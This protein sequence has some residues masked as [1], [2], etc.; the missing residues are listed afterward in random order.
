MHE[1]I[2]PS[3]TPDR[4]FLLLAF[5]ASSDCIAM[6]DRDA[7]VLVINTSGA[8]SM[9]FESPVA[10]VGQNWIA[11]WSE[12]DRDAARATL[13]A[14]RR[15]ERAS[16]NSVR[17]VSGYPTMWHTIVLALTSEGGP[18]DR[19]LAL[20]RNVTEQ[21][22]AEQAFVRSVRLQQALI[23][24]TSEIVWHVDLTTGRTVRRGYVEFTGKQDDPNDMD[25]WLAAVHPADRDRAKATA[26]KA[27][28]AKGLMLL[29]YRLL[30]K[31]EGWRWVEDQA[32]P[33]ID[34][35]G[36]VTDWV[37]IITDIHDRK[38]AEQAMRKSAEHLRLAVEATGL[39]TW[40]VDVRT[41]QRD[42]SP[43]MFDI[44]GYPRDTCP[45]R[46]LYVNRIH[47]EDRARAE[48]ELVG[49]KAL[50]DRKQVSVFRLCLPGGTLRWVEAHERTFFDAQGEP[51][52]RVGTLQDVTGRKQ[53]EH[54]VWEAAHTDALTGI[55]NRALFNRRLDDAVATAT[56]DGTSVG[57]LLV[58]LD[59]FKEINDTL[60]HDA[61]DSL[62][63]TVA[64]R[65]R[66][67]LVAGATVA[68]LGG[69]EFG[70]IFPSVS[71]LAEPQTYA[72]TLLATLEE[73]LTYGGREV[74]CSASMGWS[75]FPDH[76]EEASAL[77][78]NADVA[79]YAAKS[80]GRGRAL[81][82]TPAMRDELARRVNV[83]RQTKDALVR[84]A[85]VPFYQPKISLDTGLVVGFEAL[86]RWS[87]GAV[88]RSPDSIQEAFDD[89]ELSVK[90]GARMLASTMAD[91]VGWTAAG[92][93]FGHVALNVAISEFQGDCYSERIF[94][95]LDGAGLQSNQLEI[96]VTER[97]LLDDGTGAIG[98][99]LR[100]LHDAG[101]LI[102]LDD[103]G[104]GYASLTHLT[105]F[106][107]TWVK[108]D[109]SF[110][111]N[112]DENRSSTA[113]VRAVIALAHNIGI[114]IVAEGVETE[115]QLA[116][117]AEAGCDLGQ[118]FLLAK[119]MSG[120]RVPYFLKHW[121]SRWATLSVHGPAATVAPVTRVRK[122]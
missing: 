8:V 70:V 63:R 108:I 84:N 1:S 74:D 80:A 72:A 110:I 107:V 68:R 87:D 52:R 114:K 25:G 115:A 78:K 89:P 34:E 64:E 118:G 30:H 57:L 91:M 122:R 88:L 37:G 6:L 42:W 92:I 58:D 77:L 105:K 17:A 79:L 13:E 81:A 112:P 76:D 99:A 18:S 98:T 75:V 61:G 67:Q 45:D 33:L 100:K 109:R 29:E 116:F 54:E 83:L 97:V 11:L 12:A 46:S 85:I 20:S 7:T 82:F 39:G 59:R 14:A 62:L 38:S 104:T 5:E 71:G 32:T 26:D 103:F 51:V 65:L 56:A 95:A 55:A 102:A 113:I 2:R 50:G 43:E 23:E 121:N 117:L 15:G 106:P 94:A 9:G 16:F 66:L 3:G 41:G 120:S 4:D 119:P 60:G 35:H 27:E 21:H 40:D 22:E 90:L 86:L 111:A 101:V 69:D 24:A 73:P 10:P 36:V 44:L 48:R 19:L 31:T 47:P 28:A 96:E 93:P 49:S 53:A